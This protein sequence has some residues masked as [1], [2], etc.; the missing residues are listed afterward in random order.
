MSIFI[1]LTKKDIWLFDLLIPGLK[2]SN[3]KFS[4]NSPHSLY[5]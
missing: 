5:E 4:S 1:R 2:N 3:K